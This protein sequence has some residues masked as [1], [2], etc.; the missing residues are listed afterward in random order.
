[1]PVHRLSAMNVPAKTSTQREVLSRGARGIASSVAPGQRSAGRT[2]KTAMHDVIIVGGG[3]GGL[4]LAL[5]LHSRHRV[6][7]LRGRGRDQ[8]GRRR[9]QRAAARDRARALGLEDALAEVAVTTAEACFF[10]R[11]GQLIYREPLGTARR[12]RHCRSSRSIAATCTRCCSTRAVSASA[13]IGSVARLALRRASK[14]AS[15]VRLRISATRRGRRAAAG[16]GAARSSAATAS[17]PLLRKQL[18]PDEGEPLYSGVNMWRGVTRWP[19]FLSGATMIA[20]RLA[21]DRQ[22]GDLPDPQQHRRRGPPARQLGRRG[23]NAGLPAARLEP[24]GQHRRFSSRTT[25]TGT[26]TGS[27]CRHSSAVPTSCSNSRWSTRTRLPRWSLGRITLLGDAAHPMY[28]RG[29]NGAGQAILDARALADCLARDADPVA[30]LDAYERG[31]AKP[32]PRWCGQP[33]EAA[34]RDPARSL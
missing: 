12:L 29:S 24:A 33:Q 2:G 23:R 26:S 25:R 4:T 7:R 1:M 21:R 10:N 16:R 19:P 8:A 11:F 30:A 14:T 22:D 32:P 27:T 6:P 18:Y 28:P 15:I 34:R 13:P 31:A 5:M 3:I 17:T 9:H 20:R